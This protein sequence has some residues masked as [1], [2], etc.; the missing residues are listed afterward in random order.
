MVE[1]CLAA[2][3]QRGSNLPVG[4]TPGNQPQDIGFTPRE[5]G[6]KGSMRELGVFGVSSVRNEQR[7]ENLRMVIYLTRRRGAC[8]DPRRL[9][10]PFETA[11]R[12]QQHAEVMV[13][14][15]ELVIDEE[16]R[17]DEAG[18]SGELT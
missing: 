16:V 1:G 7:H 13:D 10:T 8:H 6:D 4:H 11:L 12:Q 9:S 14:D 3:V 15:A 17:R 2:D 5:L 18:S